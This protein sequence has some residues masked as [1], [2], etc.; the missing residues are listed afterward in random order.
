MAIDTR[1]RRASILGIG[2]AAA[3]VLPLADGGIT[4]PDREQITFTYCGIAAGS[5][6]V[7]PSSAAIE[8]VVVGAVDRVVA[9]DDVDRFIIVPAM[10]RTVTS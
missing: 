1:N 3:L 9:V 4:A 10:G 8:I 6:T 5:P 2:L 7:A